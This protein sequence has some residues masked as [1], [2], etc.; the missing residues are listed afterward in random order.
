MKRLLLVVLLLLAPPATAATI[1]GMARVHDGDT[2]TI[3][4][5][6]IRLAGIDAP[7][8]GQSCATPFGGTTA[9]GAA[10]T[11]DLLT[12]AA[13]G[14]VTCVGDERDQYDRLLAECF[15]ADGVSM[16]E[17]MVRTGL[18]WAFMSTVYQGAQEEAQAAGRGIWAA[19]NI[20]AAEYRRA[21]EAAIIAGQPLPPDPACLIKG[22]INA[23]GDRIY[24][25]PGASGYAETVIRVEQGERWFCS[26]DEAIAAGWRARR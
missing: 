11:L 14:P 4:G 18:A 25:L 17:A 13:A 1:T 9:C 23:Q 2:L 24:H 12:M 20:T 19:P 5:E 3:D 10:A 26:T 22:N 8:L 6:R 15:G 7:E 21:Q 16:N